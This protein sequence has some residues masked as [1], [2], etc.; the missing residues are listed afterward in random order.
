MPHPPPPTG[1]IG[2]Y[3]Y[4][5]GLPFTQ[6]IQFITDIKSKVHCAHINEF[7]F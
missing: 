3:G 2:P 5:A 7:L 1:W 6:V 4:G